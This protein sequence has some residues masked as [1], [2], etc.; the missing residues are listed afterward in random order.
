[1][2]DATL[3]AELHVAVEHPAYPGHFPGYP[4]LPGAALL[5]AAMHEIALRRGLDLTRW[6]ATTK[7]LAV[8]QPGDVLT[9]EHSPGDAGVIRFVLQSHRGAVASGVL[10]AAAPRVTGAPPG[11][12]D[13]A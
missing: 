13:G 5:D 1:M 9:L 6:R 2:N 11:F 8:V 3:T 12:A 4:I 10:T 7:F